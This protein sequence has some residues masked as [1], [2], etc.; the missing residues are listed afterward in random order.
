M[1]YHRH[2]IPRRV[3][4][5]TDPVHLTDS[6]RRLMG[7]AEALAA[8]AEVASHGVGAALDSRHLAHLVGMTAAVV[9][10]AASAC[11]DLIAIVERMEVP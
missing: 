10:E 7:Q 4:E 11:A 8:A 1:S 5:L 9:S 3:S 6:V 2:P